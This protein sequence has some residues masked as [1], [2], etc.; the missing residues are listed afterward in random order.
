MVQ[1]NAASSSA[2]RARVVVAS[3]SR[4]LALEGSKAWEARLSAR[5]VVGASRCVLRLLVV[6]GVRTAGSTGEEHQ[7]TKET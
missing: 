5:R 4:R 1:A 2:A 7:Q 6:H 3:V